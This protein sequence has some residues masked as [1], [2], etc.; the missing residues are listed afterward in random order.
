MAVWRHFRMK[1]KP[2][3]RPIAFKAAL[4]LFHATGW[5]PMSSD[6]DL[7]SCVLSVSNPPLKN[8]GFH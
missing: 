8:M 7:K 6:L 4:G 1:R 5:N 2:Q 3:R